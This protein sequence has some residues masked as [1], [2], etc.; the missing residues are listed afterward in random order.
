M[1]KDATEY[2]VR[3]RDGGNPA[4]TV[5]VITRHY[6][7]AIAYFDE[8]IARAIQPDGVRIVKVERSTLLG[9]SAWEGLYDYHATY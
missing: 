3:V 8:L 9:Y 6:A 7:D 5:F 4:E 1:N 2:E